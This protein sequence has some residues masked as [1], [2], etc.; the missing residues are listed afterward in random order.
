M[1]RWVGRGIRGGTK[2]SFRGVWHRNKKALPPGVCMTSQRQPAP[3]AP[4]YNLLHLPCPL[5][6]RVC[7]TSQRQP[8]A[9][10]ILRAQR[11]TGISYPVP[12]LRAEQDRRT[13]PPG[14][15]APVRLQIRKMNVPLYD[16][17][18]LRVYRELMHR[19]NS[20]A[21]NWHVQYGPEALQRPPDLNAMMNL[22][23][24]A[25]V[26]HCAR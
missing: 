4:A 26:T 24:F 23:K 12:S 6:C 20:C 7:M 21:A 9:H 25:K 1:G 5:V 2:G 8:A 16:S 10:Y 22:G 3:P 17:T 18:G 19:E 14:T 13:V 15:D 11:A